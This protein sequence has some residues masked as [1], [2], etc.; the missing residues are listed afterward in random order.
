MTHIECKPM[1]LPSVSIT[2]AMKPCAPIDILGLMT[3]PPLAAARAASTAR[4][5]QATYTSVL[6]PDRQLG[7]DA[8]GV[9]LEYSDSLKVNGQ[10]RQRHFWS[11]KFIQAGGHE[12]VEA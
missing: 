8:C 7:W 5:L 11:L 1:V 2:S 12:G 4:S 6:P 10:K 9:L 3:C